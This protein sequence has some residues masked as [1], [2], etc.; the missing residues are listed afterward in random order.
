MHRA[1]QKINTFITWLSVVYAVSTTNEWRTTLWEAIENVINL[2]IKCF[3]WGD[4][5]VFREERKASNSEETEY[6][7]GMREFNEVFD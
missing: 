6:L 4:F 1:I 3:V 7:P 5:N 2:T